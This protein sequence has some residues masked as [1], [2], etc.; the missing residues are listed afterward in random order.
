ML[1]PLGLAARNA[2]VL[3]VLEW[4]YERFLRYRPLLQRWANGREAGSLPRPGRP[5]RPPATISLWQ[6]GCA[7]LQRRSR[8][9]SKQVNNT[10]PGDGTGNG[11]ANIRS[12][13]VTRCRVGAKCRRPL[14]CCLPGSPV[15]GQGGV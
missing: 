2:A 7:M 14:T 6:R 11:R 9:C 3:R 13:K 5:V 10:E 8:P 12:V 4:L 15:P 1:R